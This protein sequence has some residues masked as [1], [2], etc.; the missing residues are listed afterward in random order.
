[1][2]GIALDGHGL[3]MSCWF[4]MESV[5]VSV[6]ECGPRGGEGSK[7]GEGIYALHEGAG[8]CW[9]FAASWDRRAVT[10]FFACILP[11]CPTNSMAGWIL[12]MGFCLI[13]IHLS[14]FASILCP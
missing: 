3:F 13:R 6:R 11:K 1:M 4:W 14:A 12:I 7:G 10:G 8:A 5:V 2:H 9:G